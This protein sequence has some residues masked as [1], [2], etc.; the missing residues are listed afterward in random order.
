MKRNILN[1]LS[2]R[3]VCTVVAAL[4]TAA[5]TYALPAENYAKNSVLSEGKWGKIKVASTGM[6]LITN[7]Q[8]KSLGF[9]DPSKVNVYG[10]GGRMVPEILA[11]TSYDLPLLPCVRTSKGILFF[12][13]DNTTWEY[14]N[15]RMT[16]FLNPYCA[17][18]YYFVSDR[19]VEES[20]MQ[21]ANT[22]SGTG[23]ETVSTFRARLYYEQDQINPVGYGR[24]LLGEDFRTQKSRVFKFTMPDKVGDNIET[25]VCFA[26]KTVN[27]S[28]SLVLKANDKTL[29]ATTANVIPGVGGDTFYNI[30]TTNDSFTHDSESLSLEVNYSYTGVIYHAR[31]DYIEL[32]YDRKLE[33]R[34]GELH[35]YGDFGGKMLELS[36]CPDDVVIWDVTTPW[37]PAKVDFSKSGDKIKFNSPRGYR[38]YIAF[39]P[40]KGGRSVSSPAAVA[41][42][43]IHGISSPDMVIIAYPQYRSAAEK[44]ANVHRT[45][46]GMEVVILTPQEVYNEFSGGHADV[47]AFRKLLKMWYDRD[48]K[49]ISHCLLMGRGSYDTKMVTPAVKS[50]KYIPLP[51]WQSLEGATEAESY[52]TDDIIGMIDDYTDQTFD[53]SRAQIRV[54]VGRLPVKSVTEANEMAAK[55]EKYVNQPEYGSWRNRV[56]LIADDQDGNEHLSQTED[57]YNQLSANAPHYRYEKVYLDSYELK[58]TSVGLTY[59]DA[60]QRVLRTWN[61]GVGYTN[62]IGHASPNSWTHE[63][64]LTWTDMV[65]IS[66]TNL[67]FLCAATCSFGH[68]D[69]DEVSGAEVMTLNP[70]AGFIGAITP[71][72]TVYIGMNGP[73]SLSFSKYFLTDEKEGSNYTVGQAFIKGK[74]EI[75]DR[76]KLRYCLISDPALRIPKPRNRVVIESMDAVNLDEQ[77]DDDLMVVSAGS[78]VEVKGSVR[79]PD[80]S[81]AEN[82]DGIVQLDLYDA[83]KVV[84]T[85]GN[86]KEGVATYYND[87]TVKLASVSA[88]VKAGLWSVTLFVPTEI[89]N[90]YSPAQLLAYGWSSASGNEAQGSTDRFYVYGYRDGENPDKQGPDIEYLYLNYPGQEDGCSVNS[91]PVL[92]AAF[93]D[94][95]GINL[96]D[97]GIGHKMTL[98]V[99]DKKIYD[100]VD[101]FYSPDPERADAGYICY[102]LEE[103]TAGDHT[104][105]L[106]VYDNANNSSKRSLSFNVAT[107]RDPVIRD[108]TTDV[109]PASESVLFSLG[110]DSP[111]STIK[112]RI[113][114]FDLM[115]KRVWESEEAKSADMQGNLSKRWNLCDMAGRRVP[116]GIYLYRATVETA[117]GR[118]SSQSKKLAV[119]AQ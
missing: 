97:A 49:K 112:C 36:G 40:A 75:I 18:S 65:N 53:I 117:Q 51:L 45:K 58:S 96:S 91:S 95:S 22:S 15:A 90:N 99:D 73:L 71:S 46:D 114:V 11:G 68:W 48:D 61:E 26:A 14:K 119:T 21:L 76:N 93:S 107:T 89:E 4:C 62:Y 13:V 104:L 30:T 20:E 27:G 118:Y 57:V 98:S 69:G 105:T 2:I 42:Q 24:R 52:S 83:E 60:K 101:S 25:R 19:P 3:L 116:R 32:F 109:N 17:E 77:A 44:I 106:T 50:A 10:T 55:I 103:L 115:G 102:P 29:P 39:D 7:S 78:K 47:G 35:F 1:I 92:H 67:T 28:S 9:S 54:A 108:L 8:L 33:L 63:K 66:N 80:G 81:V 94:E 5:V 41:N 110:V 79:N 37:S 84:E 87:R 86:G 31:L 12:G 85:L 70:T 82:F 74:N 43:N 6:Q 16:H 100:D 59:P 111:N 64:L 56:M 88:K 34:D 38:E 113:E 72:R 23:G